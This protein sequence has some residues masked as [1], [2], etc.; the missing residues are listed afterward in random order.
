MSTSPEGRQYGGEEAGARAEFETRALGH[1]S[2]ASEGVAYGVVAAGDA[3]G[4]PSGGE[5]V[6]LSG[7]ELSRFGGPRPSA[8]SQV[9]DEGPES[10]GGAGRWNRFAVRAG[11]DTQQGGSHRSYSS[12]GAV[13]RES[14][15]GPK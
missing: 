7:D 5:L 6:E 2:A 9:T 1:R 10:L 8:G 13:S 11:Q 15:Q 14:A 4:I 3:G 12:T